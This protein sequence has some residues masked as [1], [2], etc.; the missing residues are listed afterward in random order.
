MQLFRTLTASLFVAVAALSSTMETVDGFHFFGNETESSTTNS[1]ME[2]ESEPLEVPVTNFHVAVVAT[3]LS[4]KRNF[5]P[6]VGK[7]FACTKSLACGSRSS[8]A[9]AIC[10]LKSRAAP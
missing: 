10:T 2:T 6:L 3:A 7:P 8:S 9:R 5:G 1:V 4:D